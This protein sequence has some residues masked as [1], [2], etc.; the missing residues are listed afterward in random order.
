MFF[1]CFLWQAGREGREK[2]TNYVRRQNPNASTTNKEKRKTKAFMMMKHKF[3]NAQGK[4][5][6][7]EKQVR[8]VVTLY[9]CMWRHVRRVGIIGI[10]VFFA[11][12]L[13]QLS[14]G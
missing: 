5:S 8:P 11:A 2:F 6:F 14:A 4:K 13:C 7:H 1:V 3:R 10:A 9:V 12:A